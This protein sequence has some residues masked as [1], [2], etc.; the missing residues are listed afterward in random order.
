M[1]PWRWA[2]AGVELLRLGW[3]TGFRLKGR[4]WRWRLQTAFG[5]TGRP[6]GPWAREAADYA[7]WAGSM[8]RLGRAPRGPR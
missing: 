1:P 8:R 2:R 4:Y 7:L 6:P 3:A 5:P